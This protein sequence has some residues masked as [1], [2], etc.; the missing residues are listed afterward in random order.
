MKLG[1]HSV[2]VVLVA[3]VLYAG[4]NDI[5]DPDYFKDGVDSDVGGDSD[6]TQDTGEEQPIGDPCEPDGGIWSCDP[7]DGEP[8]AGENTACDHGE[9]GGVSGFFCYTDCTEA[10]GAPCMFEESGGPWCTAGSTCR[11]GI[12]EAYCCSA[13]DCDDAP[14]V[15]LSLDFL[16][17]GSTLGTCASPEPDTDTQTS[18]DTST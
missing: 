17:T 12:C 13:S 5:K 7:T 15:P 18:T 6:Q 8:C 14:C 4:C 1:P 16:T 3:A 11:D 10:E 9:Q 2:S